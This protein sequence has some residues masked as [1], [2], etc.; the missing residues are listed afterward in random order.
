M[1]DAV[2]RFLRDRYRARPAVLVDRE[3][4]GRTLVGTDD[5]EVAWVIMRW[6]TERDVV[7]CGVREFFQRTR[8]RRRVVFM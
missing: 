8:G 1:T 4:D 2:V 7:V 5:R 6:F 3:S